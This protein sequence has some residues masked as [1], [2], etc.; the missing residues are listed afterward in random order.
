MGAEAHLST[1][2]LAVEPGGS[3]T[4]ELTVRNNGTVV[5]QFT[6]EVLD[7]TAAWATVTPPTL[8][9]FPG[10]EGT[11]T[12]TFAPA[13]VAS[14]AAGPTPFAIRVN[15]QED[16][17]GSAVEE[18]TVDVGA[19]SDVTVELIPR[20][21]RGR[22]SA[23]TELAVDNR[24]NVPYRALLSGA[25]PEQVLRFGFRPPF[26]DLPAGSAAYSR[27]TL[28][29]ARRFWRG[30]PVTHTFQV[31]L[32]PEQQFAPEPELVGVGAGSGIAGADGSPF[33][34]PPPPPPP[35]GL[36]GP[37]GLPGPDGEPTGEITAVTE[38]MSVHP[39]QLS[40][41]GSM[42]QEPILPSWFWKVVVAIV[43]LAIILVILWFAL[44]KPQIK[45]SA[46][47]QVTKQL[48]AAGI[49][50]PSSSGNG[51]KAAGG[52][53]SGSPAAGGGGAPAAGG[54]GSGSTGSGTSG[55]SSSTAAGGNLNGSLLAVGNG[56]QSYTV[57]AGKRL[58]V[59]DLLVSNAAG[60][61]GTIELARNNVVLM[62]WSMANF[63]DLDYHWITPTVFTAGQQMK[64]VVSGCS[65]ACT[66]GVYYAGSLVT[67]S[68]GT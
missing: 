14:V 39:A 50:P 65:G 54:G 46:Q 30:Q 26:I 68:T 8:S 15:A 11:V 25:D 43:A 61:S 5:D 45:A 37:S 32:L 60:D 7:V 27:V 66:P 36:P 64:L 24:S 35:P 42:L 16:P 41:D 44:V 23:R 2:Q 13:R 55:S 40:A 58:E 47:N 21:V 59:T 17:G 1:S 51:S 28:Q 53:K 38:S 3:V 33:A 20:T 9:L 19:F 6:F 22:R 56:T 57:P 67:V 49:T 18:G 63:R 48:A 34:P 4:T 12:V 52:T 10:A 62:Q 29:P 31:L